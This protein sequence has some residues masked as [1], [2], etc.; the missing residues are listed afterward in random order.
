[1]SPQSLEQLK[2][3]RAHS[4]AGKP[5]NPVQA[6]W[7]KV[8]QGRRRESAAFKCRGV[9]LE[10][11]LIHYPRPKPLGYKAQHYLIVIDSQS[12]LALYQRPKGGV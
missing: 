5:V 3:L 1:M 7:Q 9:G 8:I 10:S 11:R 6:A 4:F 12:G 2:A